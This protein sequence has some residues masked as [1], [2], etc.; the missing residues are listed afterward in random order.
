[1]IMIPTVMFVTC[2]S[3]GASHLMGTHGA[4]VVRVVTL[5]D[6]LYIPNTLLDLRKNRSSIEDLFFLRSY[7]INM[8]QMR[9]KQH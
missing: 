8:V 4:R 6:V 5:K 9:T 1:M 3:K 7:R 2:F